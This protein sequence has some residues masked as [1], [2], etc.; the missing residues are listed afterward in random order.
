M[1]DPIPTGGSRICLQ[2][3]KTQNLLWQSCQQCFLK[4]TLKCSCLRLSC[5]HFF[6]SAL[7]LEGGDGRQLGQA[8]EGTVVM[9]Q[10]GREGTFPSQQPPR[11]TPVLQ[12]T[13]VAP[14]QWQVCILAHVL[15]AL[16]PSQY[17]IAHQLRPKG[18]VPL[19]PGNALWGKPGSQ[20]QGD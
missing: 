6:S 14:D 20:V 13:V 8:S 3:R 15:L 9:V 17:I 2:K 1:Q 4:S 5:F 18:S 11:E 12:C 16:P 7:P 10:G 19:T